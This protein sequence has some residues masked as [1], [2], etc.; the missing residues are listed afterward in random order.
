MSRK[1]LLGF[2]AA[3]TIV[4]A[5]FTF[6]HR[7]PRTFVN[8]YEN[9]LGTSME[10]KVLASS[11]AQAAQANDAVLAE[12]ERESKLLSGYDAQSEFSRWFASQN[13][14]ERVSPELFDVLARFDDWPRECVCEVLHMGDDRIAA[15]HR[16]TY[17]RPR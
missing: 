10:V 14:A 8:D 3:V 16:A 6:L 5:A 4:A 1:S 13:D 9:I 11:D 7:A 12:I 15:T 17:S 2:T